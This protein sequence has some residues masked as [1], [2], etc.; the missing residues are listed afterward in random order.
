METPTGVLSRAGG[1]TKFDGGVRFVIL[2]AG[3][4]LVIGYKLNILYSANIIG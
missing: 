4:T 3:K 1:G 2:Y